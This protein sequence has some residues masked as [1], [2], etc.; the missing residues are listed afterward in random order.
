M[1]LRTPSSEIRKCSWSESCI[2]HLIA[3]PSGSSASYVATGPVPCSGYWRLLGPVISGE[4][5]ELPPPPPPPPPPRGGD[6]VGGGG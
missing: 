2:F 6:G 1:K 3:V 5:L 4:R